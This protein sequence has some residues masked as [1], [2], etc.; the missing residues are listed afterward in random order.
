MDDRAPLTATVESIGSS[1][2]GALEPE[3]RAIEARAPAA[4]PFLTY[5]WLR[6]WVDV[7]APSRLRVLRVHNAGGDATAVALLHDQLPR[8]WRFAGAPVSPERGLLCTAEHLEPAWTAV[9][10]WLRTNPSECAMLD[11]QGVVV[12]DRELPGLRGVPT[13]VLGLELPRTFDE[14]ADARDPGFRAKT[15]KR[16]RKFERAA[17]QV[18]VV[19][20]GEL[21]AA[22]RDFVRLHGLRARSKR[23]RHPEVDDRLARMLGLVSAS[24]SLRIRAFE[25][26]VDEQRAGVTVRI[27][28]GGAA[29]SYNDGLDPAHMALSPGILLE[30]E[31]IRDAIDTGITRYDLGPGDYQYKREFGAVPE[32]RQWIR[33]VAPGVRGRMAFGTLALYRGVRGAFGRTAARF[34]TWRHGASALGLC[35]PLL[36]L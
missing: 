34:G 21:P 2:F 3:W 10:H 6:A 27:D 36:A 14:Y 1:G 26:V 22:L 29:Y 12:P 11:G 9:G 8:I 28:R 20:E 15:R 25:M 5:D 18:G 24:E 17:G 35:E 31:S 32:E 16:M 23:E 13:P 33:V 4:A 7:Y 19:G 30:L